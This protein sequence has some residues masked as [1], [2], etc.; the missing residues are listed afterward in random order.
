MRKITIKYFNSYEE[1]NEQQLNDT[2]AMKP[3]DR[4]LA[5]DEIRKNIYLVKGIKADNIVDRKHITYG[6]R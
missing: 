5:V 6:T 2:L 1:A 4:V 3:E